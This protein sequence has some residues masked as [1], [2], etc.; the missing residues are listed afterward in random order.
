MNNPDINNAPTPEEL[1]KRPGCVAALIITMAR[2]LIG[3]DPG[4]AEEIRQMEIKMHN[5]G[6]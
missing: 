1:K 4:I 6:E 3:H 5:Q 2:M